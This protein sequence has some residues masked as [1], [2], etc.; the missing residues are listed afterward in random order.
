MNTG[1]GTSR[2]E[3]IDSLATTLAWRRSTR[4]STN[5][6]VEIADLPDGGTAVRD[7]KQ[8]FSAPVLLFTAKEWKAFILGVTAGEFG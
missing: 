8:P 2:Q 6:C 1:D 4:C 7:S 3:S 5:S